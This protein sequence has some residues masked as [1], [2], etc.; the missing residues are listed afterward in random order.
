MSTILEALRRLEQDRAAEAAPSLEAAVLSDTPS[1]PEIARRRA[2]WIA[3]VFAAAAVGAGAMLLLQPHGFLHDER[4]TI[5]SPLAVPPGA[6]GVAPSLPPVAAAPP[7][8]TPPIVTPPVAAAE[9][10]AAQDD[11]AALDDAAAQDLPAVSPDVEP[12]LPH[13][14]LA[15]EPTPMALPV[16]TH[17]H[18]PLPAESVP[19]ARAPVPKSP[20]PLGS[21]TPPS[22][23]PI[24][25]ASV[26]PRAAAP[27]TSLPGYAASG[28]EAG[29]I[30][31]EPVAR[32]AAEPNDG[33]RSTAPTRKRI[34]RT[35]PASAGVLVLRTVWHPK[36]ERRTALL[37][38]PGDA[39]PRE[40]REGDL[41]GRL[42]LLRI[43]P[44]AVVFERGGVEI[45]EKLTDRP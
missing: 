12:A 1:T 21:A 13:A 9:V 33:V 10:A 29:A 38:A 15:A 24:R 20:A 36:P 37:E 40:Y 31:A 42:T 22:E 30:V 18:E 25:V 16:P 8:V 11:L 2:G 7:A 45:R 35:A 23:T 41:V 32:D 26:E 34:A 3:G 5:A 19:L 44:S 39:A 4:S 17:R 28:A 6:A 43:E 14:P 27:K